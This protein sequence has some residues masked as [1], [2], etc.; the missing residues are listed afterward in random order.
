MLHGANEVQP[1]RE[2]QIHDRDVKV[3]PQEARTWR[4]SV[5][6]SSTT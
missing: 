4:R 1:V 3:P 5:L 6:I 2:L